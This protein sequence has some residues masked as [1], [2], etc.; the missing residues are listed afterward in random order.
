MSG[1][2]WS[3]RFGFTLSAVGAAV[4]LGSIWRFP[5]LAGAGGGFAFIAVFVL[6]CLIFGAPVLVGEIL[7]GRWSRQS[8][9]LAAGAIAARFGYS[10]LWNIVGWTGSLAGFLIMTYYTMIAGWVMAY[11]WFF[12]TGNYATGGVA[13]VVEKFTRFVAD[14]RAVSLWQLAFI[15]L[16]TLISIRG[17]NRGVEWINRLRAPAL[18]AILLALACYSLTTGDVARGLHFAFAP[19]LSRLTPA[20]ILGAVGQALFALGISAGIII[21][22]GAYMAE[23]ESL[24]RNVIAVVGSIFIVSLLATVTIF[25]LVFRYGLNPAQGPE[26]VFQVLPVAFAQMPGGRIVGTLFF[27]LLILAALT[28]SVGLLE[29]PIAWL[30]ERAGLRRSNAALL[31]AATC[32]LIGQGSVQSF[33]RLAHWHPL[34]SV[35][36]FAQLDF[37][38]LMDFVAANLLMPLSALLVSVFVGWR[39]GG[40]IPQTQLSGLSPGALWLLMVALRYLCPIGITVVPR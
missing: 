12:L 15:A 13:P 32:W 33:N 17:V 28:P 1:Q 30:S 6:A 14:S 3:S 18:L 38:G 39:L 24:R 22:Y 16:V 25:P 5:Y 4:G 35:P 37:F 34:A 7:I 11:T 40:R 20:V 9:P 21:A 19:D 2:R 23:G 29:V 8:P 31:T 36:R 27:A 26:L 10:R